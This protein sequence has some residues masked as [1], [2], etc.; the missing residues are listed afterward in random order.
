MRRSGKAVRTCDDEDTFNSGSSSQQTNEQSDY[1]DHEIAQLTKLRSGPHKFLRRTAPGRLR[2]PVSTVEMLVGREANYSGRGRFSAADSCHV[3]SRY[4]PVN[5]P[6]KV[7]HMKTR[8]YISQF[9]ADGSLFVAGSQVLLSQPLASINIVIIL[10]LLLV[11]E[12]N[13]KSL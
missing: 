3:L 2:Q 8:V 6:W 1:F 11:L 13:Q 5:G 4:L 10:K 9:S 12:C 7:D